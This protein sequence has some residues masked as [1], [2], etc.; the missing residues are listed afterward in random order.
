MS[1]KMKNVGSDIN[2]DEYNKLTTKT[3]VKL[4]KHKIKNSNCSKSEEKNSRKT[5][6][7]PGESSLRKRTMDKKKY[8]LT[9]QELKKKYEALAYKDVSKNEIKEIMKDMD[10]NY[11]FISEN[12]HDTSTE[13]ENAELPYGCKVS[14]VCLNITE[15]KLKRKL[16]TLSSKVNH[17]VMFTIFNYFHDFQ[18]KKYLKLGDYL[19]KNYKQIKKDYEVPEEIEMEIDSTS[20]DLINTL[21][22]KDYN[23]FKDFYAFVGDVPRSKESF[24][25]FLKEKTHSWLLLRN[26]MMEKIKNALDIDFEDSESD[27]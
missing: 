9:I 11:E 10:S 4:C 17:K 21:L 24:I 7:Y 26:K 23:D 22:K 12:K 3:N 5:G 25:N 15:E 6:T 16:S 20:S 1:E 18:R 27:E 19:W 13:D 2:G 14:E 8:L